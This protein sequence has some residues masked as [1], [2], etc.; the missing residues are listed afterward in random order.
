[1]YA[2]LKINELF[3]YQGALKLIKLNAMKPARIV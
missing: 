2:K 1:M 3:V